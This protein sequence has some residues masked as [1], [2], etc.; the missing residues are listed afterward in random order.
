M[1]DTRQASLDRCPTD[2]RWIKVVL[3]PDVLCGQLV[4]LDVGGTWGPAV[5]LFA[6]L[7]NQMWRPHY[8]CV[9]VSGI[10]VR[11]F[12]EHAARRIRPHGRAREV[13]RQ[14]SLDFLHHALEIDGCCPAAWQTPEHREYDEQP[15][16]ARKPKRPR[17]AEDAGGT[18][19][20]LPSWITGTPVGSNEVSSASGAASSSDTPAPASMV[21]GHRPRDREPEDLNTS[22][23]EGTG[24]PSDE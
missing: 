15:V 20:D 2:R 18:P 17:V 11:V 10:Y 5:V 22:D 4:H 23:D 16:F 9:T 1:T 24:E 19:A 6:S 14:A 3:D 13:V 7:G 21:S 12:F 8:M